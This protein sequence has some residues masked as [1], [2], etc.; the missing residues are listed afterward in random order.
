MLLHQRI[1]P[2]TL[3]L[4]IIREIVPPTS[5][6]L[7]TF[8]FILLLDT[9]P[10]LLKILVS[11]GADLATIGRVFLN[12]LPS[13]F[14]VTIP[15]AFLLGVLLAFGRLASESELIAMR[16]SGISPGRLLRPLLLLCALTT[17]VT[18][19]IN[20]VALP[21]SNQAY[22][23]HVFTLMVSKAKNVV[24]PRVFTDDLV[25]GMVVYVS[26]IPADTGQW[27]DVLIN[28]TRDPSRPGLILSRSGR[29]VIDKEAKAVWLGLESG[30][31]H[32]L[33]PAQPDL[34]EQQRFASMVVPLPF[35]E[36]FP[37]LPLAKGERE[38]TLGELD[39]Q[40]QKLKAEGKS[41]KEYARY[42]VE[43]HKKFAISTACLVFGLLGL[44]LSLGSRK[45]ARSAAFG[46]SIVVIFT[47]YVIIRM[48]EQAG[49]TGLM[50]PALAMW[51][52]N[53]VLGTVALALLALNQKA[54]AFDPLDP[55]QY[56][57]LLPDFR[58]QSGEPKAA[59]RRARSPSPPNRRPRAA[60]VVRIPRVALRFPTLLDRYI[61]R[62]YLGLF[63]L[64][65]VAFA[66]IYALA[67]FM[68]LFDDIQQNRVKGKVVFHYYA[69]HI[70]WI[71][72]FLTPLAVLV[73]VLAT[74]GIL[75]RR[76]EITA[77]KAGG[78]SLYRAALPVVVLAVLLGVTLYGM[79]EMLLP[80]T[81]RIASMDYNVIKGRP[82]QSSGLLDRRWILGSD[83]RF[84]N[85]DYLSEK[86]RTMGLAE[87]RER[88][89]FAFFGLRV[90]DLEPEE[91]QLRD[92]L[93]VAQAS[94]NGQGYDL[95]RGWRRG[96]SPRSTFRTFDA[97]RTR[98]LEP[99]TY[100]TREERPSDSMSFPELR[101]HIEGLESLGF[102]TLKLRVQ[103][104][105][106]M[107]FPFSALVMVLLGIPF[108][109]VVGRRGALYGVATSLVIAILYWAL[110]ETFQALGENAILPP[111]LAAWAPNLIFSAAGLYLMLNLET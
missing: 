81:N 105:R 15:M 10:D 39:A 68:D 100:F 44:A 94:W 32:N 19:Y 76:N 22:R 6:G 85:Y 8:T 41:P 46:L 40:V 102:D 71:G 51:G 21:A 107:A 74:L 55:R 108:S 38:L 31:R 98:D 96:L 49:D 77:M 90:Y 79:Q 59:R 83:N 28:D 50:P 86:K 109:F 58:R 3:D 24:R 7:L 30:V 78:V 67:E 34:Y 88:L 35:D 106:K 18:F 87:G 65:L 48:G 57:A 63:L 26:D 73:G 42:Q 25:P 52:A 93:Y 80:Y 101:T 97:A 66:S 95:E 53:L 75:S 2:S 72:H 14:A 91:W 17:G 45:E 103:L 110:M 16:A 62:S 54:A 27:R 64:V 82:P 9:I 99:P 11:R 20:A 1:R 13:I 37:K 4:Y 92:A 69:Y 60:V 56:R 89:D 23:E 111:F 104:H 33:N 70:F 12:L 61:G 36:F 5:L 43:W 29:L 47:Y 84:Y